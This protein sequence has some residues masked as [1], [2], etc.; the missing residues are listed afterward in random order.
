LNQT[1]KAVRRH[2]RR[3]LKDNQEKGLTPDSK[4]EKP[5]MKN[6][7]CT[8]TLVIAISIGVSL[9]CVT[10]YSAVTADV[11]FVG[12]IPIRRFSTGRPPFQRG[13]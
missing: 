7:T 9:L 4:K 13:P 8:K 12:T 1:T 10:V 11:L 6:I 2:G 5:E 3:G